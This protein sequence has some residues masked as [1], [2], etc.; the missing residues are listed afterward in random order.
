MKTKVTIFIQALC[1]LLAMS[2]CEKD[3]FDGPNAQF[4]GSMRDAKT[5]ELV[6]TDL[7]NGSVIEAFELGYQN[8]VSQKWVIKSNGEFRNNLVFANKYDIYLRNCN[9]FP[10]EFKDFEIKPGK[11][12]CDFIVEPY[13]RVKN[14]QIT[15]DKDNKK[16]IANFSLEAGREEV[17]VK[18]V[19]L[20][21]FSDMYVGEAVK[22]DVKSSVDRMEN[23]N[24]LI[25]PSIIYT[26]TIDLE[27]NNDLFKIGRNYFF[28]IGAIANVAGVGTIKHNYAPYVMIT[29]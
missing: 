5:N 24:Q 19:R 6:E 21:A 12:Q 11:N 13:I 14:A 4:Y 18:N 25:N 1:C 29:L 15:Y 27:K 2:S 16:V 23:I 17:K 7:Q 10:Q 28:R 3:N 22:F 20:Y 8:P 26:L 9:F